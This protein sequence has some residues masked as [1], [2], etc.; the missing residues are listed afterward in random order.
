M[1]H[2]DPD[3]SRYQEI[4]LHFVLTPKYRRP[5]FTRPIAQRLEDLIRFKAEQLNA[6]V[7][8]LA[9]Q[10]DH[11]HLLIVPDTRRYTTA[12]LMQHVKGFTSYCLR[13]EYPQLAT[14]PALWGRNY[15]VRSVGGG[16]KAVKQYIQDQGIAGRY[17]PTCTKTPLRLS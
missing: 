1:N 3:S 2:R 7:L 16:R 17:D 12:H 15:F 11:V 8:A 10:P 13:L 14:M 5:V 6:E 9:V 4:V